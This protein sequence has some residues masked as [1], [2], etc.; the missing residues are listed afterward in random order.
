[1]VKTLA[2]GPRMEN[3]D[4]VHKGFPG[5]RHRRPMN[6]QSAHSA[7]SS[8]TAGAA[9]RPLIQ[10]GI[11]A[12]GRRSVLALRSCDVRD[13]G[14]GFSRRSGAIP[15]SVVHRINGDADPG[16][17]CHPD[18]GSGMEQPHQWRARRKF[19]RGVSRRVSNCAQPRWTGIRLC[20]GSRSSLA[21]DWNYCRRYF[22]LLR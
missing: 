17:L 15:H 8:P 2:P 14:A 6:L 22:A 20:R 12:P 13:P 21:D 19:A 7:V 5:G 1:M 3:S 10:C 16:D 18:V 4:N 9:R 11:C